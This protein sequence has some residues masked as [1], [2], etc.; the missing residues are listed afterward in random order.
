MLASDGLD[1]STGR[2]SALTFTVPGHWAQL[3]ACYERALASSPALTGTVT[4]RVEI[5]AIGTAT[6]VAPTVDPSLAGV[7]AC[8]AER[9]RAWR[10]IARRPVTI[11]YPLKLHPVSSAH[12]AS[13]DQ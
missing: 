9:V 6:A 7:A 1:A 8:F 2:D 12:A 4:L 13:G 10:F 5:T 3:V 11:D